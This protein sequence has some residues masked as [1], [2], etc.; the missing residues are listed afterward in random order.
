MWLITIGAS[1]FA[2]TSAIIGSES[3]ETS[4]AMLAPSANAA[5][6]TADLRV[7]MLMGDIAPM[8]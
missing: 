6:A 4:F 3:I 8:P 1:C 2:T 5:S 7:S